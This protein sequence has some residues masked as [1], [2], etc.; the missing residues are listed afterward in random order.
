MGDRDMM[1]GQD[2]EPL[3]RGAAL[4]ARLARFCAALYRAV[5]VEGEGVIGQARELVHAAELD[6]DARDIEAG[7]PAAD[8]PATTAITPRD[9][10]VACQ[11]LIDVRR[12]QARVTAR[13]RSLVLEHYPEVDDEDLGPMETIVAFYTSLLSD[14]PDGEEQ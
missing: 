10:R 12:A 6:S 9:V 5:P 13:E 1:H 4:V 8:G 2:E 7:A 14:A 11:L 3:P